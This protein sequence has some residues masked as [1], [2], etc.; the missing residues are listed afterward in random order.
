M[1]TRLRWIQAFAD[2][3]DPTFLGSPPVAAITQ[4]AV[5][6]KAAGQTVGNYI[7]SQRNGKI[8]LA[9]GW[10]ST[11]PT[12]LMAETAGTTGSA[13][14]SSSSSSRPPR[15]VHVPGPTPSSNP[16]GRLGPRIQQPR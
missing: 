6:A 2:A 1:S 10:G 8:S 4:A 15:P 16:F 13:S 11:T 7:R 12:T 14:S 9:D 5:Q 3:V